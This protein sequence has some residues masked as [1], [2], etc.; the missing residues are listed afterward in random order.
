MDW[1]KLTPKN[2][3]QQTTLALGTC[4]TDMAA[5]LTGACRQLESNTTELRLAN[6][7]VMHLALGDL[8]AKQA[9]GTVWE[10]YTPRRLPD[11]LDTVLRDRVRSA[12]RSAFPAGHADLDHELSRTL[13]MLADD[14]RGLLEKIAARWT[15]L[16]DPVD[17]I[18]Y[19]IVFARLSAPR[20]PVLRRRVADTL[21]AL[22]KKIADR[23]GNRDSHW[24]LRIAELYAGLAERDPQLHEVMLAHPEFGRPD[25]ALFAQAPGFDQ[26][27]AA[28]LFLKKAQAD[29]NFAWNASIVDLL[30]RLPDAQ[31]LPVLRRLWGKAGLDAAILPL[32]ARRPQDIDR[33]KFVQGLSSPNVGIIR[34]CLNALQRLP[35]QDRLETLALIRTLG[36]LP[37]NQKALRQ[38]LAQRLQKITGEDLGL[39]K[40]AWLDWF[41]NKHPDLAARLLN[42]DGVDVP[43]WEKRL[44][45]LD[46]SQGE[47]QRGR[48]VFVRASCA[49]CHSGSQALGPDL[50][51]VAG[52]FSRAD[53]FT[54]IL[55]PSRDIPPRY[56]T[57]FVETTD[58]KI[59][60]GLI[61]YEAVDSLILQT[62]AAS[63]VRITNPQIAA[64][65]HAATSLMPAGLLDPLGDGEI[66]DLYAYLKSLKGPQ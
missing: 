39:N 27:K 64:R 4:Q 14:D 35:G 60:Q 63:T 11:Q 59:Y 6:V 54:A 65:G 2:P 52:R 9:S 50:T 40:K 36:N 61:V 28:E 12:L 16:S 37:D 17:D 66:A 18:H 29:E 51:G 58:G 41:S 7:R 23:H 33:A 42:P 46:W 34:M 26:Y 49:T 38:A 13:A 55:Q 22:D 20:T 25:H 31:S 19:L 8:V 1:Q 21:L 5:A 15:N 10:G 57:T 47:P 32:L 53:L 62:G 43:R 44:A 45:R 56:Q 24:P 48:G 3:W 30:G